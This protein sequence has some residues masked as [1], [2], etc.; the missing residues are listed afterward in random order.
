MYNKKISSI[1]LVS[2]SFMPVT[3]VPTAKF[4][5]TFFRR[6]FARSGVTAVFSTARC[7]TTSRGLDSN[8]AVDKC[9]VLF[10]SVLYTVTFP[11]QGDGKAVIEPVIGKANRKCPRV[12]THRTRHHSKFINM[13]VLRWPLS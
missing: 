5:F 1:N 8:S 7:V 11:S 13:V 9:S 6:I 12:Y 4:E 10:P 3:N 2:A